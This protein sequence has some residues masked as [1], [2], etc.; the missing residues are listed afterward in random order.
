MTVVHPAHVFAEDPAARAPGRSQRQASR[1]REEWDSPR[2]GLTMR[3]N[4]ELVAAEDGKGDTPLL[5]AIEL[6]KIDIAEFFCRH[7]AAIGFIDEAGSKGEP[8]LYVAARLE[9][10]GS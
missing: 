3:Q 7:P 5:V 1:C 2:R 10:E 6:K 8:P 4:P 9:Q